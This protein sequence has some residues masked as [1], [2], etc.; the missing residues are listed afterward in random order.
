[1]RHSIGLPLFFVLC[2]AR[3]L[4]GQTK[5]SDDAMIRAARASFNRAIAAHDT[6][7]MATFWA[8]DYHG[9]SSRNTQ[10]NGRDEE[11]NGWPALFASP[12]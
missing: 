1:M 6:A 7:A 11:R 10:S 2:A 5:P 9:V 4:S 12:T 3:V 8:S